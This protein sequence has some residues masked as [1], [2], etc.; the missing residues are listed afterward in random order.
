QSEA[1]AQPALG[2]VCAAHLAGPG[3]RAEVARLAPAA[4]EPEVQAG[5]QRILLDYDARVAEQT[6]VRLEQE[7]KRLFGNRNYEAVGAYKALIDAEPA[8]AEA[9]MDLTQVFGNLQ[10]GCF[11]PWW[12]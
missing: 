3:L 12:P 2:P 10:R 9:T 11:Q 6:A 1:R 8:N 7:A 4:A 5:L